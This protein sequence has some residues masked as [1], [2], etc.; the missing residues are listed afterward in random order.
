MHGLPTFSYKAKVIMSTIIAI[1]TM[2]QGHIFGI[3]TM[4]SEIHSNVDLGLGVKNFVELRAE[5]NMSELNSSF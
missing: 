4:V 2:I 5:L 1:I 3:Y